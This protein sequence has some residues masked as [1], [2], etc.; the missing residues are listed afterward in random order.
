MNLCAH[1]PGEDP[2]RPVTFQP[3]VSVTVAVMAGVVAVLTMTA[4]T[5]KSGTSSSNR[6]K[7]AKTETAAVSDPVF[8][9]VAAS[10]GLDFV[11]FNGMTGELYYNEMMGGGMALFDY[12]NDGDLDVYLTQGHMQGPGTPMADAR[13]PHRQTE[14]LIDRLYR[15]DL[16]TNADGNPILHFTDVT[17][18]SG[19]HSDGYGMGVATGDYDNDGWVDLYV[20][21]FGSNVL[22]RNRGDGTFEDV[23]ASSGTGDRNWPIGATFLDFDRDGQLDLFSGNYLEFSLASHVPCPMPSGALTYC[24]PGAYMPQPDTLFRNLGN[25]TF[26]DVSI[27]SGIRSEF[28]AGMGVVAADFN[29]DDWIDFFVTNDGMPNQL[30]INRRDGTFLNDGLFAGVSVNQDGQPEASMGVDAADF[31]GDGDQDLFM[32]HLIRETNTLYSNDGDGLF[33]DVSM[34]SGLGLPSL[35][36]TSFGTGWFDYDNDSWLDLLT[37][38][39]AVVALEPQLRAGET[40]PLAQTNQLFH[41]LGNGRFEDA[42]EAAGEAFHLL[43]VSRGAAFGDIDNDGDT[44][45]VVGNSNGPVRL[46]LN[47]V[48][49]DLAWLGLEVME[50]GRHSLGAHVLVFRT[51]GSVLWHR[52]HT[53]GSYASAGD[54]RVLIGLGKATAIDRIEVRWP[55]GVRERWTDVGVGRYTTLRRGEG[56]IV[57]TGSK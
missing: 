3:A 44:D 9:D 45:V 39:G 20:T 41:S 21:N 23:T 8:I 31:D 4:C 10:T 33:E 55:D 11:H 37:V 54:P 46:L 7:K 24:G 1:R 30:W 47:Q 17:E 2:P 57:D 29:G 13:P 5:E 51:G 18:Q 16:E 50:N 25:G 34:S 53:D 35:S 43:E 56:R 49:Q 15:N 38:S 36:R 19:I 6:Q 28:G 12:D 26:Q 48:G 52:V 32:T 22:L 14:E 27:P 42:S 40:Y